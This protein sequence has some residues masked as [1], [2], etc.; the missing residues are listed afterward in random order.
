MAKIH[1]AASVEAHARCP[2]NDDGAALWQREFRERRAEV[3]GCKL[4]RL[5]LDHTLEVCNEVI[6]SRGFA[7]HMAI[8]VAKLMA[9]RD[10]EILRESVAG[11]QL[12]TA[13]GQA[14]VWASRLLRDT[15]P[16]RVAG[17]DLMNGLLAR[18]PIL[19]YRIYILGA[20][21]E[22]LEAAVTRIRDEHPGISLVGYRDGYYDDTDEDAVAASIAEVR[23]DILF[24]AMSSPRKE[25]FLARHGTAMRV[26]FVM[27]VGGAI[28][29]VAGHTRRAP[30]VLQRLGL[31]WLFRLAQEPRRLARRYFV[32]NTRF[33]LVLSREV[34]KRRVSS[35]LYP[36][37]ADSDSL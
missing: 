7:Q 29:I 15:L 32:T 20:R 19:G 37:R 31:E 36:E 28:D 4:D 27:G 34:V 10:D 26:P 33:L 2:G 1:E 16:G 35:T 18:A 6:Q 30:V 13:D 17:I 11:C 8:N 24:V 22:V 12:V 25:Y 5:D 3:L 14:V 23:P 21:P 9:M